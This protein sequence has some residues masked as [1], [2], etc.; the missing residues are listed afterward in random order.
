MEDRSITMLFVATDVGTRVA[1][2]MKESME[3]PTIAHVET[4]KLPTHPCVMIVGTDN[5]SME[6]DYESY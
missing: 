6:I 4:A 1:P 5:L 2:T 3:T